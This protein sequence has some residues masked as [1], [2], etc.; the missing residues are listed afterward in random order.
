MSDQSE[1]PRV[2]VIIPTRN[3]H[4][5]LRAALRSVLCQ[6]FTNLEIWIIDDGSA[7][8][9]RLEELL[10]TPDPRLHLVRLEN[11]R[12][13][14]AARNVGA[15]KATA[16]FL[17]FLDD[18]DEWLPTKLEDQLRCITSPDQM[19]AVF[20]GFQAWRGP[21]LMY[22]R[23]PAPQEDL[24]AALLKEPMTGPPMVLIRT[25]VFR[26]LGGFDVAL[27]RY[28]DWDLWLRL[29]QQHE[30]K[31]LPRVHVRV[32]LH[33]SLSPG[34]RLHH[35]VLM[36]RRL[37]PYIR[38]F[39]RRTRAAARFW[40]ARRLIVRLAQI[41]VSAIE[42]RAWHHLQQVKKRVLGR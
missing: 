26:D 4:E 12:G 19:A 40:H 30:M 34:Q 35:H 21:N 16:P 13:V 39:P 9:V 2:S 14:A 8:P 22:T 20:S 15:Q 32:R 27:K 11:R 25:D 29:V 6:T 3:R 18:D 36:Y 28:E 1:S 23:V 5:L 7:P 38:I 17:A 37:R 10:D 41:G 33:D 42:P 31:P 24:K